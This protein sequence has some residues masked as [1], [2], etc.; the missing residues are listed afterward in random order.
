MENNNY[1]NQLLRHSVKCWANGDYDT[2]LKILKE[3][4][5]DSFIPAYP[6]YLWRIWGIGNLYDEFTTILNE[7]ISKGSID[8]EYLQ[9]WK[10]F[11]NRPAD[12]EYWEKIDKLVEKNQTNAML[13]KSLHL[14]LTGNKSAGV[15][16]LCDI[17]EHLSSE[18][19]EN[20]ILSSTRSL[21]EVRSYMYRRSDPK[22]KLE[23]TKRLG[24]T[25]LVDNV[26]YVHY[27]D[28][29]TIKFINDL[30]LYNNY[31][32]TDEFNKLFGKKCLKER[33]CINRG[34]IEKIKYLRKRI[35]YTY[36]EIKNIII[37]SLP[38][39]IKVI[40]GL[41]KNS[42][43]LNEDEKEQ[44]SHQH[45]VY[46]VRRLE[47]GKFMT[48]RLSNHTM[49]MNDYFKYRRMYI[50]SSLPYANMCIMFHGDREQKFELKYS[51]K[52]NA[53]TADPCIT[54]RDEDFQSY[55]PFMYTLVHYIPGMIDD[56]QS[57]I[58]EIIRWFNGN[59]ETPFIDPYREKEDDNKPTVR[60]T[61]GLTK[62][63]TWDL[64]YSRRLYFAKK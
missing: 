33:N 18:E 56:F 6:E 57:L 3:L 23:I 32:S 20:P 64:K 34:D 55:R 16:L 24:T 25:K 49:N 54:V 58:N 40:D 5:T 29:N 63:E 42:W 36:E 35:G 26:D 61:G 21:I 14:F 15:N 27:D 12:N 41:T 37:N 46:L 7:G 62:I 1:K 43:M 31:L 50:P 44:K 8:C 51:S 22:L 47:D 52:F 28:K 48:L 11:S 53:I 9:L 13:A 38:D 39:D 10:E 30:P 19:K 59:G 4:I 60:I 17:Y 2:S 45:S